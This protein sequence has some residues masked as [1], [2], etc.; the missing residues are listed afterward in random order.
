MKILLTFV[1]FLPFFFCEGTGLGTFVYAPFTQWMLEL[2]GWR[3]T[4]LILA[5]TLFN[6][7]VCGCLMR[8]PDWL[9]E[10]NR[11]ESRSQSA[12][13]LS[14][15]SVCLD[16]IK[17]MLET[18]A[19][20]EDVLETLVTNV[21]TEANQ[22]IE[23]PEN[24]VGCKKY[25][26]ETHLPTY[27]LSPEVD[28][29]I[30]HGSRRSLR[31]KDQ[32]LISKEDMFSSL[33]SYDPKSPPMTL[34]VDNSKSNHLASFE[35]LNPSEKMSSSESGSIKSLDGY[36]SQHM[37]LPLGSRLS[38]DESMMNSVAGD[39]V[40]LHFNVRG[41]SL[42]TLLEHGKSN[43]DISIIVPTLDTKRNAN[44]ARSNLKSPL[45]TRRKRNTGEIV[46]N[47]RRNL[48]L[49]SS[50]YLRNMRIHRNSINYRGAMM[51]THRYRLRAS[52]CPN[53][54]RNSMTTLA[55]A[56]DE[57]TI[58]FTFV[59]L[60][61]QSCFIYLTWHLRCSSLQTWYDN[62]VD[63]MKSVFDF[64]LFLDPKFFCFNLSTLF[65]FIWYVVRG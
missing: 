32:D 6:V 62:F 30:R 4:T 45:R 48:P 41:N 33:L 63:I 8:D 12:L 37:T 46:G 20:A 17:K 27:L 3:G 9:I 52:S 49:R 36:F 39:R 18:G 25:R 1:F 54:Y 23:N 10:E 29:G 7:C 60:R 50:N 26:S 31:R 15:S 22:Q 35:T 28:L 55:Q 58:I 14:N 13:T 11:L 57:V 56:E 24:G 64:S 53:I 42:G 59:Y 19:P 61:N 44:K 65:L 5:G 34:H 21:N 40:D 2:F 16:D 38:L 51:N 47:L 43:K